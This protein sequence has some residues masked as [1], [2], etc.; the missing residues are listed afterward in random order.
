MRNCSGAVA[1]DPAGGTVT[2]CRCKFSSEIRC[3]SRSAPDATF[4]R[5]STLRVE[6]APVG[7]SK[8]VDDSWGLLSVVGFS[9][10]PKLIPQ[11][12]DTF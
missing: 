11:I 10:G 9:Y 3:T 5:G 4:Q 1:G 2:D 8:P 12:N 6:E 7:T